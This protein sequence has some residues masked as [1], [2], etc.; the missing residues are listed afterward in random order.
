MAGSEG[1]RRGGGTGGARRDSGQAD[2]HRGLRARRPVGCVRD[3]RICPEWRPGPQRPLKSTRQDRV[4]R[5]RCMLNNY[6]VHHWLI[7]APVLGVAGSAFAS[8]LAA[9]RAPRTAFAA[10]AIGVAGIIATAG[11]S[12]FP[13]LV[14]SSTHPAASL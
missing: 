10:S 7:A 13:F 1:G 6:S 11:V 5:D 14:P 4:A 12:L 9:R 8:L 3:R 2:H